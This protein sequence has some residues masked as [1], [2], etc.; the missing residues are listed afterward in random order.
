VKLCSYQLG[1]K[2]QYG[3]MTDGGIIDL[4]RRIGRDYPTLVSLIRG[5]AIAAAQEVVAGASL[6][7]EFD[8]V[9]FLPLTAE[10]VNIFCVGV[11]Y[12]DHRAETGRVM[13]QFP[14]AF[15]KFQESLVGHNEPLVRPQGLV[16]MDFEVEYAVVIGQSAR[17]VAVE[18]AMDYVAGY[19]IL[20]DGT[21]REYQ[22]ERS[23]FQ[24]KNFWHTGA[25]GPCM[26][27]R[28]AAPDWA[29]TFVETR[30][31]GNVMQRSGVDQLIMDV[32][33]LV[34]YF[35]RQTVLKP[36]DII[37]TGTPAG[38]GHRRK[39][40]VYLKPGDVLEMEITGIGVLRNT[41]IDEAEL[42]AS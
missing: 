15:A 4:T 1:G 9:K 26:L 7:V 11:N 18:E 38:V 35:S 14:S 36:G 12:M 2:N 20:N 33:F 23:V 13:E 19:T 27:T 3:V 24:G 41:V 10:P 17:D 22:Y 25:C 30:L 21:I 31:N 40:P 5:Q 37:A 16:S 39:P 8:N 6:D 42:V 29:D 28:D 32:P 34:S